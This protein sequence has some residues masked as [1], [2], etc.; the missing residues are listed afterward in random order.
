MMAEEISQRTCAPDCPTLLSEQARRALSAVY[1]L[2]LAV[3]RQENPGGI[4]DNEE[5]GAQQ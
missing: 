4:Y 5:S 1:Q 2:L 3:S